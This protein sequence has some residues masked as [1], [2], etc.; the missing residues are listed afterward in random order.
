M[1]GLEILALFVAA[2]LLAAIAHW[3]SPNPLR[4]TGAPIVF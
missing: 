3:V 1:A 4:R 2:I